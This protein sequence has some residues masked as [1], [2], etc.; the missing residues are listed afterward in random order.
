MPFSLKIEDGPFAGRRYVFDQPAVVLGRTSDNDVV[1]PDE[2]A[3]RKHARITQDGESWQIED[4]HSSNGTRVNGEPLRRPL[5][6]QEA[7]VIQIGAIAFRFMEHEDA[8]NSTRIVSAADLAQWDRPASG[9]TTR[10]EL[11]TAPRVAAGGGRQ[12]RGGRGAAPRLAERLASLSPPVRWGVVGGGALFALLLVAALV[13]GASG[14]GRILGGGP[15]VF[16]LGQ[17]PDGHCYGNGPDVDVPAPKKAVFLFNFSEPVEGKSLLTFH[18]QADAVAK[19]EDV[20]MRLNGHHLGYL[21]ATF[22]DSRPVE[23]TLDRQMLHVNAENR[24]EF[25]NLRRPPTSWE[26]FGLW[27]EQD[28]LPSGTAEQ[29]E[30]EARTEYD[31]AESRFN[32]QGVAA[33]NLHDAWVHYKRARLILAA[34]ANPPEV[35]QSL[36]NERLQEA[37]NAMDKLCHRMLFTGEQARATRGNDAA[38]DAFKDIL[39]YFPFDDHPCYGKA[40]RKIAQLE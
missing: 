25:V 30:K 20:E 32:N 11:G 9:A 8:A 38:L 24:I 37:T 39:N 26:V 28:S 1:V 5:A 19:P 18:C 29:L 17:K 6:L 35:L 36:V 3:S 15:V 27:M 31:L 13:R 33:T 21:P 14:S 7:D 40:R 34:M 22:G 10:P 23:L 4:L 12:G 16:D 2:A